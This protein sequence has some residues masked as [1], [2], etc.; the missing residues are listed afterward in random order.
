MTNEIT[1]ALALLEYLVLELAEWLLQ[2]IGLFKVT[3]TLSISDGEI[4]LIII[5]TCYQMA[6]SNSDLIS[7]V[8]MFPP[9]CLT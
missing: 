2:D 8:W 6:Q 1:L 3:V 7:A 5:I 4:S 9:L